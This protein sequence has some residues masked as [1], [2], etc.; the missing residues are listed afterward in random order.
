MIK[1]YPRSCRF[2]LAEY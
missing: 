2:F 1:T